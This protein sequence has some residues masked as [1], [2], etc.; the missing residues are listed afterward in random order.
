MNLFYFIPKNLL[1]H[2]VIHLFATLPFLFIVWKKTKSIKLIILTIFITII[3]DI[4]HI[5]DYFLYYCFSLDFIKFLKADYFSQ[6]G[7]AYVLFHGWEWLALLV[8]INM[9]SMVNIKKKWKTF[10]FILLFAYTPHLILDSL[11]VG[12]FLFYSILYRLFHSFTYLV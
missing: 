10:W 11:N 5:L 7:H 8:I 1:L 12:S 4:D 6:S 3:I 2:E 9:K